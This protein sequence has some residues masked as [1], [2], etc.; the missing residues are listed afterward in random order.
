MNKETFEVPNPSIEMLPT[1]SSFR[2][3]AQSNGN[4]S[5]N[6]PFNDPI[7]TLLM[8]PVLPLFM[9][10]ANIQSLFGQFGNNNSNNNNVAPQGKVT[11]IIRD[12][13]SLTIVEKYL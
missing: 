11:Q 4:S 10:F 9:L 12:D 6:M 2:Q 13:K 8:L 3:P 7:S 1:I 5:F